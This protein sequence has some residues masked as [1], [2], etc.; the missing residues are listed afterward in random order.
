MSYSTVVDRSAYTFNQNNTSLLPSLQ[1][2]NF[3]LSVLYVTCGGRKYQEFTTRV[4]YILVFVYVWIIFYRF[5]AIRH[6]SA[7]YWSTLLYNHTTSTRL[8]LYTHM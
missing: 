3:F 1:P 5:F 7:M 8:G 4:L 2:N 6:Y